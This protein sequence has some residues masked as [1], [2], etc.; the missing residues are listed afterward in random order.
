[1]SRTGGRG[2]VGRRPGS[3]GERRPP[4]SVGMAIDY[5]EVT[6]E[7]TREHAHLRRHRPGDDQLGGGVPQRVRPARGDR[8]PRGAEHHA[9]RWSTSAPTRPWSVRRPRSG[10][11]WA[12][13]RSPASS[14]P[15]WATPLFQLQFHGKTYSATDLSTLVLRRLKEDAE[16]RLGETGRS[17]GDH[18]AGLFRRPPAQGHDRGRQGRRVPGPADHQRADRRGPGLRAAEGRASTRPS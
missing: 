7:R 2:I 12:T 18:R 15:T 8:Q 3:A 10:P 6:F 16:A 4:A 17:R 13:R 14:S 11:G 5:R 1:M 9:R